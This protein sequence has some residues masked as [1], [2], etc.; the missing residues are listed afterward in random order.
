MYNILIFKRQLR[1][2]SD[3]YFISID[4]PVYATCRQQKFPA[5]VS[6]ISAAVN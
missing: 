6:R 5:G 4:I 2:V 3:R 1:A